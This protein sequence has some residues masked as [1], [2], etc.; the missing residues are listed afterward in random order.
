MK[1]LELCLSQGFGGLELYAEKVIRHYHDKNISCLPVINKSSLLDK[2]LQDAQIPRFYLTV[3][4]QYLPLIAAFKLA[5]LCR[6]EGVTTIH[7]HWRKDFP[8]AVFAKLFCSSPLRLVYTRQMALTREKRDLYHK[9]LYRFVDWY[10]TIT[11]NLENEARRY[12]PLE[13]EKIKVLY[14]GV[15][16]QKQ[17][18]I[19]S[20]YEYFNTIKLNKSV[21]TVGMFGRIERGKGQHLLIDSILQLLDKGVEIQSVII[22]HIMDQHYLEALQ[23]KVTDSDSDNNIRFS[24][25]HP[26]PTA[27]MGC[28]DVVVLASKAETFGLVLPEAMRA[29]TVVIGTNAGGVP[30]IIHDGETGLLFS[31]E[32]SDEL[33]LCLER[34]IK[35]PELHKR[36]A[37]NGKLFADEN[38]SEEKHFSALDK[39]LFGVPNSSNTNK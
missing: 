22:G 39:Y 6:Q 10:L 28:F 20:C 1:L 18:D 12:L 3:L 19:N 31:P 8:L 4:N 13:H 38:F 37:I 11:K 26:N 7:I 14:Y 16:S 5:R 35:D 15:P 24:G 34:L 36:L 30:E 27:I 2:R 9:F 29:G 32:D 23:K 17:I 33:A 21:F 25:F